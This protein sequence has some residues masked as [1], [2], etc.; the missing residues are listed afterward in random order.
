MLR[1]HHTLLLIWVFSFLIACEQDEKQDPGGP[2]VDCVTSGSSYHGQEVS[3]Q[4]IVSFIDDARSSGRMSPAAR[5]LEHHHIAASKIKD[6]IE[7]EGIS[8]Y[9]LNISD[10]EAQ[11]LKNNSNVVAVEPDRYLSIKAC[12]AVLEP[13]LVTWNVKKV[14]YG[15]GTTK[16]A[17]ILDT[18]IDLDHPDLNV[19]TQRSRSF[20]EGETSAE[21]NN[22]HGTHIAG[23]IGAKN[24]AIGT[25]GVASGATIVGLKILDENGEGLLSVALKAIAYVKTNGRAGDAVNISMGL[26]DVSEILE[27]EVKALSDKGIYVVIAAG[28]ESRPA[29][30]FSP[31]R[32]AGKNIYTITAVDSTNRFASFSNYGN[33]VVDYAA[34][35]VKILST[36]KN[37]KYAIM[38]GTSMAAPHVTGLLLI[39]NGVLNSDGTAIDDPDGTPDPIVHR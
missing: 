6:V 36:Y 39:N 12:F 37:G 21:D 19:D 5:T 7:G 25:L 17:W 38:S 22:G 29:N 14:G 13:T 4:Y 8:N 10:E 23:V 2:L 27:R 28:N 24:N 34:P 3:D 31:A 33:D 32:T 1:R 11:S 30:N 15:D 26:E 9:V 16:T 35:G 20:N 18:G